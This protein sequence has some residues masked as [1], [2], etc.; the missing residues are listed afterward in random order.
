MLQ[1]THERCERQIRHLE[2]PFSSGRL[3]SSEF[4]LAVHDLK[5]MV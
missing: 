4:G 2:E 3:T 5:T 1:T